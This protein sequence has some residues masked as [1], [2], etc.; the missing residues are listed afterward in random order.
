M[1]KMNFHQ[2]KLAFNNEWISKLCDDLTDPTEFTTRNKIS[3]L[4]SLVS[5]I[6][7]SLDMS[8]PEF[9]QQRKAY[10]YV[11]NYIENELELTCY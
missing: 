10:L 6:G 3:V 9:K 2:V 1:L 5:S 7:N 11:S 4:E 8:Y